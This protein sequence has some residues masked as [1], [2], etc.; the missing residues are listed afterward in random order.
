[1]DGVTSRQVRQRSASRRSSNDRCAQ[2][3][4]LLLAAIAVRLRACLD[5][6]PAACE[7]V[8]ELVHDCAL[9]L[10]QLRPGLAQERGYGERLE[11][12][13]RA[14]RAAL[15][16]ARLDLAGTRDG[17]RRALH[18]ADHDSL[19]ALPNRNCFQTRLD[20]ALARNQETASAGGQAPTLA[21][22][23]LDL[24]DFKPINDR[25]GHQTGDELLRIVAQRLSRAVRAGDTVSRLGGDEFACL[26]ATPIGLEQLSQ[27]ASK[28]FDAISA[29]LTV[30]PLAL[31]V[32]PSI[33]IAVSPGDGH[34][35]AALLQHADTAMYRAKRRQL[36]YS[37]FD[38]RFDA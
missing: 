1:M 31:T 4:D 33:G 11:R 18:L 6:L 30:G 3:H 34:T 7:P 29:P 8:R 27:L 19:T 9:A 25:H 16:A 26:L 23:F 20:E 28:L 13:L 38:A 35:A 17:E 36:G 21:V 12:E 5:E 14:A 24:D 10:E 2:D 15:A 32:R 37:F 22:L